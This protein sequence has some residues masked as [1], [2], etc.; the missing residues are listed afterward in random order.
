[1]TTGPAEGLVTDSARRNG[2]RTCMAENR[3]LGQRSL[4]VDPV[5][6]VLQTIPVD[7]LLLGEFGVSSSEVGHVR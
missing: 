3:V 1:M 5:W 7:V 4:G 6:P 2:L